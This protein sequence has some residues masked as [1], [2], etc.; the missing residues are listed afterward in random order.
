MG[1]NSE[2]WP[3][4]SS[5]S[6]ETGFAVQKRSVK[7]LWNAG[8]TGR[9]DAPVTL[10][11]LPF[12]NQGPAE[13]EYFVDGLSDAVNG[14]LAGLAGVSVID[15]RSTQQYKKT[16]KPVKQIGTELGVQYVLGGVVRWARNSAGGWRAQVLPTSSSHRWR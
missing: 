7:R 6:A 16:T 3:R 14:K 11:V 1:P 9:A 15:R 5:P 4:T 10:A 8:G 12:E 2:R 13:Q